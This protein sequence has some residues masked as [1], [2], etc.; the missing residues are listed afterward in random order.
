MSDETADVVDSG[1]VVIS[2]DRA[3]TM[4]R[5]TPGVRGKFSAWVKARARREVE[6]PA[7]RAAFLE[8][9]A[10]GAYNWGSPLD[11]KG[12][13]SAVSAALGQ[14][15]GQTLLVGLLL[16]KEHGKVPDADL[17]AAMDG[18]REGFVEALQ[19]CLE[20]P[21]AARPNAGSAPEGAA[22]V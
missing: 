9:A 3:W 21:G 22:T 16:E 18:N 17:A 2:L 14:W 20:L 15:E 12:M 8:Q 7:D 11:P 19:K 10:A 6:T 4:R 1:E 13:G 5:V